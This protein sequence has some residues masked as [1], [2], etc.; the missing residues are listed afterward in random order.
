MP[1]WRVRYRNIFGAPLEPEF[2]AGGWTSH[3]SIRDDPATADHALDWFGRPPRVSSWKADAEGFADRP[4]V[5]R[6]KHTDR[7]K[8]WPIV[9]SLGW[10]MRNDDPLADQGIDSIWHAGLQTAAVRE[11]TTVEK[12][13]AVAPPLA[14]VLPP[15]HG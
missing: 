11:D 12:L 2:L 8:D 15:I 10:L 4:V 1:P 14:E 5:A 7:A 3:I 9:D 6:M 13:L